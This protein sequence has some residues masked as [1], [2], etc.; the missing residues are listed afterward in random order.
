MSRNGETEPTRIGPEQW[1]KTE[2]QK[3]AGGREGW[4][5]TSVKRK[6]VLPAP[7]GPMMAQSRPDMRLPETPCSN[8]LPL[9][10]E[11]DRSSNSISK[12]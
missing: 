6:V 7:L 2:R 11:S 5:R 3:P 12:P 10:S 9:A 4:R 1:P 8:F